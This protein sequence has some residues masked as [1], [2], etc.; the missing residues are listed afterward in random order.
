MAR[1]VALEKLVS[2]LR[3]E[4]RLS[5]EPSV[6]ELMTPQLIYQL[7]NAQ[8]ELWM[9][10]DW[11]HK[12]G[13]VDVS[14]RENERYYDF[15][16][17]IDLERVEC[18]FAK[19]DNWWVPVKRGIDP[20]LYNARDSEKCE[21]DRPVLRW[22]VFNGDQFEVWPLPNVNCDKFRFRG[23]LNVPAMLKLTDVCELDSNLLVKL[24]AWKMAKSSDKVEAEKA[25]KSY[26]AT[27]RGRY[28]R[29]TVTNMNGE[30]GRRGLHRRH[31][32]D[33]VSSKG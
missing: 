32:Y 33:Y 12:R 29:T 21:T 16:E 4:L 5:P 11:S 26:Y 17:R 27:I 31:R 24:A 19:W 15:P 3:L 28:K 9:D 10:F 14:L 1:G 2:D 22:D 30:I 13:D 8:E 25:F 6:G 18:A 7:N 20:L 23:I